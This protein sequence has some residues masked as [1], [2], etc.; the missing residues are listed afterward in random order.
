MV[1]TRGF[2]KPSTLA[3]RWNGT[4]WSVAHS[5]NP[6]DAW[7][8]QLY[9]VSCAPTTMCMSVGSYDNQSNVAFNLAERWNGTGWSVERPPSP[10]GTGEQSDLSGVSCVSKTMCIAVGSYSDRGGSMA[11]QA[12][13]WDGTR[14]SLT[15]VSHLSSVKD[16]TLGAVS[17][18]SRSVCFAVGSRGVG[19]SSTLAAR[20]NGS[21]WS[22]QKTPRISGA[23]EATLAGVSCVS[24][25]DCTAVGTYGPDASPDPSTSSTLV[26]H[27][28]GIR[29]TIEPTPKPSDP[30]G[31]SLSGV[32]CT[33]RV[34]CM[35]VGSRGD[36]VT[37]FTLAEHWN[38]IAWSIEPTPNPTG[39]V[40]SATF[41]VSCVSEATCEAVGTTVGSSASTVGIL[42][43]VWLAERWSASS[44]SAVSGGAA[45]H[46]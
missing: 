27:W 2:G 37:L 35:A 25:R 18:V 15:S 29:W 3:A 1:G 6:S 11:I 21:R 28:N 10:R 40:R 4:D 45:S 34:A 42:P 32:S 26:E 22:I 19:K 13:R 5:L 23:G 8:A 46:R 12:E 7:A 17:C 38:G 9:S 16:A 41:G 24:E 14:W 39:A 20:W 31:S 44:T 36:G 43:E 33:S 30:G